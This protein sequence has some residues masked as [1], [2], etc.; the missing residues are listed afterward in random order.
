MRKRGARIR[1]LP[2]LRNRPP[3][4]HQIKSNLKLHG[5]ARKAFNLTAESVEA[6][7]KIRAARQA[8]T[9][10]ALDDTKIVIAL[11]IEEGQ[12]LQAADE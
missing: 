2:G 4:A 7:N 8:V 6:L 10:E 1:F 11:L 12:R 9:G 3:S 5:G